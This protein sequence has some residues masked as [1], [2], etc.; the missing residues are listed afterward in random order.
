[1]RQHKYFKNDEW[2][3]FRFLAVGSRIQTWINGQ[4]IADLVDEDVYQTHPKGLIGL[5][6]NRINKPSVQIEWRDIR[7]REIISN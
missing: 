6:V 2:N 4:L 3:H 7:I 5:P 1:M